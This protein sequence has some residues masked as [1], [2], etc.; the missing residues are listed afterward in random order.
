MTGLL[1]QSE[2]FRSWTSWLDYRI[3]LPGYSDRLG[4]ELGLINNSDAL[5]ATRK[6]ALINPLKTELEDPLF[7]IKI[8]Q[9]TKPSP[10]IL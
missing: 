10:K 3:M 9:S 5:E 4:Y 2:K 1:A 6:K 7:S 8:R